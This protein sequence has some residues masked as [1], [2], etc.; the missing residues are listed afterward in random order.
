VAYN[1][2]VS[3]RDQLMLMPPLVNASPKTLS[4]RAVSPS[5]IDVGS[6]VS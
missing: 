2:M 1:F 3:D 5:G 6:A 4:T